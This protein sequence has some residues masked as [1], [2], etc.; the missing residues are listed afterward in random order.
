MRRLPCPQ[1]ACDLDMLREEKHQRKKR[2]CEALK[3][4]RR[5]EEQ[6]M[7]WL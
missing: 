3:F 5:T 7:F 4:R 6:K 2:M 1:R